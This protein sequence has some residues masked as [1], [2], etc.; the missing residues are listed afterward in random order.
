MS[1]W[2]STMMVNIVDGLGPLQIYGERRGQGRAVQLDWFIKSGS[3]PFPKAKKNP[4][5]YLLSPYVEI[6]LEICKAN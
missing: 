4:T 1:S 6:Q 2:N 5:L 3:G